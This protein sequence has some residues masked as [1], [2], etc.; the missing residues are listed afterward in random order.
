M[1]G[2][3]SIK[4]PWLKYSCNYT[5][6]QH[7]NSNLQSAETSHLGCGLNGLES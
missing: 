6:D 2:Q 3:I 5:T 4:L 7:D 1:Y